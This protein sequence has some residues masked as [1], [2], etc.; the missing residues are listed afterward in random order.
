VSAVNAV[1]G[2]PHF[3]P[4][5]T[6]EREITDFDADVL[7]RSQRRLVLAEFWAPWCVAGQ[8]LHP[9]LEHVAARQYGRLEL[10][11]VN[12]EMHAQVLYPQNVHGLPM[13]KAYFKGIAIGEM[14]GV[15]PEATI[16]RWVDSLFDAMR[17]GGLLAPRALRPAAPAKPP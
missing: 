5:P 17:E 16:D 2:R 13:V 4:M 12:I 1:A 7:Q 6:L 14:T 3:G 15:L 9:A 11:S 8:R 10:V